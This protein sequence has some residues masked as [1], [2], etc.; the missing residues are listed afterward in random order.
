MFGIAVARLDMLT[1]AERQRYQALYCGLC[2]TLKQRYGQT[3]R[4]MLSYEL[5]FLAMLYNS[6][7]EPPEK[8]G[9][10][11]CVSHPNR[12]TPYA[13]SVFTDY[14][15]DL[16]VALAYHKCLDDV[17]D[18]ASF[19]ARIGAR[20]LARAYRT[21]TH[22]IP[23]QAHVIELTMETIRA[24]EA[25]PASCPDATSIAFGDMLGLLIE[26]APQSFPDQWSQALREFGQWLGRFILLMD[27]AVDRDDDARKGAYNPFAAMTPQPSTQE[28]RDTLGVSIG[29]A[30]RA[31][32]R[33]PLVQDVHIM[34][35]VLYAG[36]WQKFNQKYQP[37]NTKR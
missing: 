5:T 22:F 8:S 18:D 24:L 30:C 14:C 37:K 33:L 29:Q 26:C 27:A 31:F 32:E 12:Q 21:C 34:R 9:T 15:A 3:S 16:S 28:I 2:L 20:A 35:S 13:T 17:A 4:A 23:E 10:V 36:M 6:L 25:D 19:T 11:R 7:Y 1:D